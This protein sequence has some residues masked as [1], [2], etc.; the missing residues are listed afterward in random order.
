MRFR[1]TL[2]AV[3]VTGTPARGSAVL[4]STFTA[5]WPLSG[6]KDPTGGL[7]IVDD[8]AGATPRMSAQNTLTE[9]RSTRGVAF[10]ES[11]GPVVD[12]LSTHSVSRRT[13]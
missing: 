12:A 2:P 4:P 1:T 6:S 13:V 9:T 7:R 8:F 10:V 5:M 3:T 11:H